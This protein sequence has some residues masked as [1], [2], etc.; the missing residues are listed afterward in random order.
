MRI[1][2]MVVTYT[3]GSSSQATKIRNLRAKL[4]AAEKALID[5]DKV[6]KL[7]ETESGK[8]AEEHIVFMLKSESLK[9]NV[10]TLT[11]ELAPAED[12]REDT[13]DLKTRAELVARF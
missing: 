11:A 9:G 13:K 5:T 6:L 4:A 10:A 8:L 7:A 12:E 3:E 1:L 2:E